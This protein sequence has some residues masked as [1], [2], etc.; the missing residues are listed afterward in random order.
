MY[1]TTSSTL[2]PV[3]LPTSSIL[4]S[5]L[6]DSCWYVDVA[7][8]IGSSVG[9]KYFFGYTAVDYTAT[10]FGNSYH[11]VAIYEYCTWYVCE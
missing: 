8:T 4:A 11:M 10:V 2:L 5:K 1:K 3:L 9:A 6:Y 7:A